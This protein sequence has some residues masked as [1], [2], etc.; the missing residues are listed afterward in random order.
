M[1]EGLFSNSA[2]QNSNASYRFIKNEK[3]ILIN[4]Y[5]YGSS[6]ATSIDG[7]F[8]QVKIKQPDGTVVSI[9]DVFFSKGGYLF[10]NEGDFLEISNA[11][12]N[13]GSYTIIFD[14]TG[15]YSNSNYKIK[16]IIK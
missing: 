15:K 6:L 10:F 5:E 1:T 9:K 14:R 3:S 2:T 4:V 11:I 8:E 12:S 7:T 16:F 13:K